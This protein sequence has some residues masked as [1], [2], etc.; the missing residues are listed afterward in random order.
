MAGKFT[1]V[2]GSLDKYTLV[3][4]SARKSLTQ[5]MGLRTPPY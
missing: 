5:A 2:K 4:Y 1:V 3:L